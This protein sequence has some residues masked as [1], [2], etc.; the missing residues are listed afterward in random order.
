MSIL[1]TPIRRPRQGFEGEEAFHAAWQAFATTETEKSLDRDARSPV[2]LAI[3]GERHRHEI[4]E[5]RAAV[6]A[7]FMVWMGCNDGFAL[8]HKCASAMGN[9]A[10][11]R[12]N[13]LACIEAWATHNERNRCESY[14]VRVVEVMLAPHNPLDAPGCEH[15]RQAD[16]SRVPEVT[17]DDL[18][19]IES[20][21]LWLM[22]EPQG[23]RICREA[24][25]VARRERDRKVAEHSAAIR[26][27]NEQRR[28][29]EAHA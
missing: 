14:G 13:R 12:R 10:E 1:H 16:W 9:G 3:M 22:T 2:H 6:A 5:R 17:L 26:R 25:E 15:R 20:M 28:A 27:T 23:Q 11:H 4:T 18:D 19:V 24:E 21:L 29:R 8:R 7:T